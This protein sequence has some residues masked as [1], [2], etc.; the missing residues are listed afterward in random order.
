MPFLKHLGELRKRLFVVVIVLAVTTVVMYLFTPQLM[1]WLMR[2]VQKFLP[3][4]GATYFLEPLEAFTVRFTLGFWASL[5]VASPVVIWEIMG[6]LL[7]ALKPKERKFVVPTFLAAVF[8]FVGGAAFCYFFILQYSFPWLVQQGGVA[9]QYLPR[10]GDLIGVL[11]FFLLAF[12]LAFQVPIVVFYLVYFGIVP[13]AKLRHSWRTVYFVIAVVAA[14]STPDWA[15]QTMIGLAT[16]MI[17]LWEG[18]MALCAIVLRRRIKTKA[19]EAEEAD[20]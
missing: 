7:P 2:P 5:F 11:E 19:L 8:L 1:V 16:A 20:A 6:F 13:Y 15:P 4:G 12:G 10:A 9:M 18:S 14:G 3:N 17:V